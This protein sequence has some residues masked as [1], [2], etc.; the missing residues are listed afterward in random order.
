MLGAGLAAKCLGAV[1]GDPFLGA[2][3][4]EDLGLEGAIEGVA[5]RLIDVSGGTDDRLRQ[6]E[7]V[8][9]GLGLPRVHQVV[10]RL[11]ALADVGG[12]LL[13]Q[14]V[15]QP[16]GLFERGLGGPLDVRDSL[17]GGG[18]RTQDRLRGGR[19]GRIGGGR[20]GR[21]GR[22]VG[23]I[24]KYRGGRL[25]C[26]RGR[27]RAR[28]WHLRAAG[29]RV[30]ERD[31]PDVRQAAEGALRFVVVRVDLQRLEEEGPRLGGFA[32]GQGLTTELGQLPR[33][34]WELSCVRRDAGQQ[35]A[36]QRQGPDAFPQSR[37]S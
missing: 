12:E 20:R 15:H 4:G 3:G 17:G 33:E 29:G 25:A 23:R 2:D 37:G 13:S 27:R 16:R 19:D 14:D 36:A 10:R 11:L 6:P 24:G 5:G 9:G 31:P 21:G 22:D 30:L 28:G 32:L 34:G 26:G 35:K 8:E 1:L 7:R 18:G